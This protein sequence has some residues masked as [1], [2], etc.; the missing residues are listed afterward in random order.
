M[1]DRAELL[2]RI[3]ALEAESRRAFDAAQREADALFAQY[4]LSQLVA[5]GGSL[6]SV[7]RSVTAEVVRLA[8]VD[9]GALWFGGPEGPELTLLASTGVEPP[10][11]P[12]LPTVLATLEDGRRWTSRLPGAR[13]VALSDE[14]PAILLGLWSSDGRAPD[15]DGI[16]VVQLAR[17]ELVVAF[18]S[19][20]L[21]ETLERER[22]ELTAVVDGTADVILQV[23]GDRRVVRLNP[24]GERLLGI[25]VADAVGLS[26]ADVLGCA[27]AGGHGPDDCPLLE[28]MTTGEPMPYRETAIRG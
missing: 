13:A 10:G 26:C 27:V 16:R 17:H 5:A 3:D 9:G 21:R 23:D 19:A 7:A 15:A 22:G 20:R 12:L 2:A 28:V 8:D 11:A 24:A 18:R 6:E 25:A 1:S 4:Q 14:P